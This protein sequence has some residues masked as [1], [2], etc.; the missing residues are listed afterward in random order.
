MTS[1]TRH[2]LSDACKATL[3]MNTWR[4]WSGRMSPRCCSRFLSVMPSVLLPPPVPT[5]CRLT[6]NHR[7]Q[8]VYLQ[9]IVRIPAA[10][11]TNSS[12][13]QYSLSARFLKDSPPPTDSAS[14]YFSLLYAVLS[15]LCTMHSMLCGAW[16]SPSAIDKLQGSVDD[17]A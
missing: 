5:H 4:L 14:C 15:V 16:M 6:K 10:N 3:P 11:S 8:C 1:S 7:I 9:Q 17:I 13:K 2:R 12:N